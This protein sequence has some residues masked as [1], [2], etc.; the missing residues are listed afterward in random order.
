M[1]K[2]L[3]GA[4]GYGLFIQLE[5][6]ETGRRF[7]LHHMNSV[8]DFKTGD[9]VPGGTVMGPR[10]AATGTHWCSDIYGAHLHLEHVAPPTSLPTRNRPQWDMIR[11]VDA[12]LVHETQGYAPGGCRC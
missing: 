5:D 10:V 8:G 4:G 7:A 6:V 3:S 12:L 1:Q 2:E 9:I 11:E